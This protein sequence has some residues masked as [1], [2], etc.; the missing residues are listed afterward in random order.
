MVWYSILVL[1]TILKLANYTD[2]PANLRE[3]NPWTDSK[4]SLD[5]G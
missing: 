4:F 5:I 1:Q 3:S 2:V